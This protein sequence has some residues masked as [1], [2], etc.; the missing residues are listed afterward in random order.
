M[1]ADQLHV[2]E[3]HGI[4]ALN[5][6]ALTHTR[7]CLLVAFHQVHAL[8]EDAALCLVGDAWPV[9]R[10]GELREWVEAGGGLLMCGPFLQLAAALGDLVPLCP[11]GDGLLQQSDPVLGLQLGATHLTAE[12]L[13]LDPDAV[14]KITW[15]V[16]TAAR[17]GAL[18]T[19]CFTDPASHPAVALRE[20]GRGRVAAVA[21]R[22][23]WGK[24]GP[25]VIWDGW[26]Q[27]HRACF[28][29]LIGWVARAW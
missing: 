26:G 1:G 14:V 3:I 17:P 28:G 7:L 25:N 19:L 16:P 21:S 18:V 5:D 12:R 11:V 22:P 29:G 4:G 20:A 15:W 2:R 23:A 10:A 27:Y 24:A 8:D 9:E 6:A 13:M